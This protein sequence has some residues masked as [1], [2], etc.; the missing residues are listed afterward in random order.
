MPVAAPQKNRNALAEL[1]A[2][3]RQAGRRTLTE[4][5]SKQVLTLAGIRVPREEVVPNAPEAVRAAQ[6]IGFPVVLKVVSPDIAH[7]SDVGG[8]RLGLNSP[9]AVRQACEEMFDQIRA[10]SPQARVEGVLVGE[11]LGGLEVILGTATDSTFGLVVMFG[12]GGV[13][14][15]CL[16]DVAFRMIP[17]DRQDAGEMLAEIKGAP[18][19]NG[20]RGSPP[21]NKGSI[22]E[23]ILN[24]S[25]VASRFGNVIQEIDI[26][27][28]LAT[29]EGAVAVDALVKL[30]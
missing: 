5:E 21:V 7:K 15:E 1:L 9:E 2:K 18:L 6:E 27:P 10:R 12:L 14:V 20:F 23:A 13:L 11:M 8:V 30:K 26:N 28:L 19:L 17:L 3:A 25:E 22:V 16:E 4:T 29:P 24:L